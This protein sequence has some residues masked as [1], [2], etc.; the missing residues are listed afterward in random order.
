MTSEEYFSECGSMNQKYQLY[1]G[2]QIKVFALFKRTNYELSYS[3]C[4]SLCNH[5]PFALEPT[6]SFCAIHFINW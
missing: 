6:L 5:W 4:M 3:L 2:Y 1:V